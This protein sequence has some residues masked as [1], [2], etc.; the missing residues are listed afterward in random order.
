MSWPAKPS[1]SAPDDHQLTVITSARPPPRSA[2]Q[3]L[4]AYGELGASPWWEL[5]RVEGATELR[6]MQELRLVV[7]TPAGVPVDGEASIEAKVERRKHGVM[8]YVVSLPGDP[9]VSQ[10]RLG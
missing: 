7:R 8:R 4:Q 2:V 10:F 9:P 3:Y 5:Y 1:M 6:G